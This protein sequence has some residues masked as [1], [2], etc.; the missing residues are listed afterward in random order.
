[1]TILKN[2]IAKDDPEVAV[3]VDGM[4]LKEYLTKTGQSLR[5]IIKSET[6][7]VTR[8]FDHRV[9]FFVKN[10]LMDQGDKGMNLK[11]FMYRVEFQ[12]R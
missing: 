3:K 2:Y 10:I 9:K 11:Y 8:M 7:L 6:F 4:T 5:G 12:A 1:M